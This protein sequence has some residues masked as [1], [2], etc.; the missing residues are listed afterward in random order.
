[1]AAC[2]GSGIGQRLTPIPEPR[3]S[4][5]STT[6]QNALRPT[7]LGVGRPG[8][9]LARPAPLFRLLK[10]I[11]GRASARRGAEAHDRDQ[12][13]TPRTSE[14][15]AFFS[16]RVSPRCSGPPLRRRPGGRPPVPPRGFQGIAQVSD[17][18]EKTRTFTAEAAGGRMHSIGRLSHASEN[19]AAQLRLFR[20]PGQTRL[21]PKGG[22]RA[23]EATHTFCGRAFL[24]CGWRS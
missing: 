7:R 13:P 6:P 2:G 24:G 4:A 20:A 15:R 10:R 12:L 11:C 22:P 9:P 1:M 23:R 18:D 21:G 14:R 8:S 19:P 17:G 5:G 16:R 3:P